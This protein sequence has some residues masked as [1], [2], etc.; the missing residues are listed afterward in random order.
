MRRFKAQLEADIDSLSSRSSDP[1]IFD[2]EGK[3]TAEIAAWC[4]EYER[5]KRRDRRLMAKRR[6]MGSAGICH[7]RG[8]VII[9]Y[10]LFFCL[11]PAELCGPA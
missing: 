11:Q 7:W 1:E 6:R 8:S 5:G 9:V 4:A 3:T 10:S 2:P